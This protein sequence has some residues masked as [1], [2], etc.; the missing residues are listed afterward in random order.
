MTNYIELGLAIL[1]GGVGGKLIE[2]YL[3][4]GARRLARNKAA[5]EE[6]HGY[7]GALEEM[8]DTLAKNN[9]EIIA[10][11]EK[12]LYYTLEFQKLRIKIEQLENEKSELKGEVERLQ[13]QI[14]QLE[15]KLA[16]G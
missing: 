5:T 3:I 16:R 8:K 15:E 10:A 6:Y 4:P 1:G 14:G 11:N 13:R 9:R 12:I 7:V 2:A